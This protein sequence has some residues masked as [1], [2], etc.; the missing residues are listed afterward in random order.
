MELLYSTAEKMPISTKKRSP[1]SD[2]KCQCYEVS[3]F[4][5]FCQNFTHFLWYRV[6]WG[7][8]YGEVKKVL[9]QKKSFREKNLGGKFFYFSKVSLGVIFIIQFV[10]L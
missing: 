8:N 10:P 5:K 7:E 3:K 4:P 1:R 2:K 6:C 9:Q